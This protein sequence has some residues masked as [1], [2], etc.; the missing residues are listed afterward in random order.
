MPVKNPAILNM[1][2]YNISRKQ[3][4][5]KAT[6]KN[7]MNMHQFLSNALIGSKNPE[8]WRILSMHLSVIV[9]TTSHQFTATRSRFTLPGTKGWEAILDQHQRQPSADVTAGVSGSNFCQSESCS[10]FTDLIWFNATSWKKN[11][12]FYHALPCYSMVD[13]YVMLSSCHH[14]LNLACCT[15]SWKSRSE[16]GR[17]WALRVRDVQLCKRWSHGC[18][19]G[20]T[21]V[22][23][24]GKDGKVWNETKVRKERPHRQPAESR[25]HDFLFLVPLHPGGTNSCDRISE[26]TPWSSRMGRNR[27]FMQFPVTE[28]V[29]VCSFASNISGTVRD[30]NKIWSWENMRKLYLKW[31]NLNSTM[32]EIAIDYWSITLKRKWPGQAWLPTART[33]QV[34]TECPCVL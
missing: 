2:F 31:G 6:L 32:L 3:K 15:L 29:L 4:Q 21:W 5:D 19:M 22:L 28:L 33:R 18:H 13:W 9:Y 27:N 10:H 7:M 30:R 26:W 34:S 16:P 1:H 11:I 24:T 20:A 25:S 23:L 17:I 14:S 12:W 8:W